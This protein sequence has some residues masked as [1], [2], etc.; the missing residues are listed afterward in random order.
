MPWLEALMSPAP[1]K[2][3]ASGLLA[4]EPD[5]ST[6]QLRLD[7]Y[8]VDVHIEDGFART[9]IDQTFFNPSFRQLEGTFYFSAA[10]RLAL[11]PRHVRERPPYGRRHGRAGSRAQR[12]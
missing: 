11:A 4:Q 12:L 3:G 8:L 2:A 5:G 1:R 7:A 9:T 6:R 10:G